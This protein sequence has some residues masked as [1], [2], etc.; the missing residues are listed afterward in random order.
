MLIQN[1]ELPDT[2]S[3]RQA[4]TLTELSL[5]GAHIAGQHAP[6]SF[7]LTFLVLIHSFASHK[8]SATLARTHRL[9][10]AA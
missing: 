5:D 6:V 4:I 2:N 8:L 7:S 1:D 10:Y 3:A 9:A